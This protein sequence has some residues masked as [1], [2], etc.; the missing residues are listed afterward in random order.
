MNNTLL[1]SLLSI[2]LIVFIPS[3]YAQQVETGV[4]EMYDNIKN[5]DGTY[6]MTTH[7]P[8][9]DD[10]NGGFTPYR[11]I[12]TDEFVQIETYSGK[13]VFDKIQGAVTTFNNNGIV[14]K[15]DSYIVRVAQL[16]T[17]EWSNLEVNNETV[18]TTVDELDNNTV[19]VTFY[20][21]N[22]EGIFKVEYIVNL[23]AIK[24]TS[25][26]TNNF[27]ESSKFAFTQT[28][29]LDNS[30]ISLV[31]DE[32]MYGLDINGNSGNDDDHKG[33]VI[34][35]SEID[36]TDYVGQSFSRDVLE[37]NRDLIIKTKNMF[38]N[39]GLGFDNLWS[40]NIVTPTK[41]SLDYA[42]IEETQTDIGQTVELDPTTTFST[43]SSSGETT[44]S[45]TAISA[46]SISTVNLRAWTTNGYLAYAHGTNGQ[47]TLGLE[48]G[49]QSDGY[50]T[51]SAIT[52]QY[53]EHREFHSTHSGARDGNCDVPTPN[54]SHF[55]NQ[56]SAGSSVIRI[57][58]EMQG[59]CCSGYANNLGASPYGS[60]LS[61]IGGFRSITYTYTPSATV[62]TAPQSLTI[63]T[64][65]VANEITLNWLAPSDDGGASI[66]V[67]H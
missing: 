43:A 21:E 50:C 14:T 27:Y 64:Q 67:D 5:D 9:L 42:N 3:A 48:S 18:V 2:F 19:I 36:L 6:T 55:I 7:E 23:M 65:D 24:T 34:T 11:L 59:G 41:L 60:G 1:L 17:D 15:S 62:S 49:S 52:P 13:L 61:S 46:S 37:N 35:E 22:Y 26:F 38:Y 45:H 20:R 33:L 66:S 31:N 8:Y 29:E 54:A 30:L 44:I 47:T 10:F 63:D 32:N 40:V 25:Y 51:T 53:P 58:G 28:I 16:D 12:E 56:L 39:A 4:F 57:Y